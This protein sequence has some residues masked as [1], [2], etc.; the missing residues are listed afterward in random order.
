M[1]YGILRKE[2]PQNCVGTS[3]VYLSKLT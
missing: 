2:I 1:M 3:N